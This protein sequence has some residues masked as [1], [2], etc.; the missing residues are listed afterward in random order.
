MNIREIDAPI[1]WKKSAESTNSL[2]MDSLKHEQLADF[3][4]IATMN[5]TAGRG[6]HGREWV[7]PQNS[8][9]AM[10]VLIRPEKI[11]ELVY[12]LP[13]V[14]GIAV[15]KT[16]ENIFSSTKA[17]VAFKLKWPN[18]VLATNS[19]GETKKLSGIL[20]E[21]NMEQQAVVCGIG[22][23][24][25]MTAEQLPVDTA[26]SLNILGLAHS[27]KII[28]RIVKDVRSGIKDALE[29]VTS[30]NLTADRIAREISTIGSE[31]SA[32][33]PTGEFIKGKAAG[34]SE[35]GELVINTINGPRAI[36]AAEV[37]HL[38]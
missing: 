13:L 35:I 12:L 25:A 14:A 32:E 28:Q 1:I 33:L 23:N 18:D 10:S 19:Q 5:Q 9:L 15:K 2:M 4:V 30:G 38:R 8:S 29:E 27:E 6:R 31:V 16:L 11:S 24:T 20:C 37:T 17:D 3:S 21:L 26:T 22:I 36:S 7:A 34:L